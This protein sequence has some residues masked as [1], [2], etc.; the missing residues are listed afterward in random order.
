MKRI[1]GLKL[2]LD[3]NSSFLLKMTLVDFPGDPVVKN[4]PAHVGDM[5]SIPGL[6][7]FHIP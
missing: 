4:M 5:G 3:S 2:Y 1:F 6:G 7:M